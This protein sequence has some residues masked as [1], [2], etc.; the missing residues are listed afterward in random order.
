MFQYVTRY[1]FPI[2]FLANSFLNIKYKSQIYSFQFLRKK[3]SIVI[4]MSLV[5]KMKH[6][7]GSNNA[8]TFLIMEFKQYNVKISY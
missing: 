3:S 2:D 1:L 8:I 5:D 4:L 7:N 6:I